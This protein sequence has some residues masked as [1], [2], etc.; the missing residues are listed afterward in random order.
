M[1]N[2]T[3]L[4]SV[5][6]EEKN[7]HRC[8]DC[9]S[10]FSEIIVID[11]NS[12][13]KTPEIV[14]E[15]GYEL[16]NFEWNGKFPK[17]RNWALRNLKIKNDWVLFLDA[18]E[19]VNHKFC[20]EL[21]AKIEE[22]NCN[23]FW[24]SYDNYFLGKKLS[25]GDT[26]RK[27]PLIRLGTGEFEKIDEDLWSHLDMEVHEHLIVAGQVGEMKSR[28]DHQDYKGIEAYIK[29]HNAYS[30]SEAHRFLKVYENWDKDWRFLLVENWF[31]CLN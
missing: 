6:N 7:L 30:S 27:L 25:Y 23:G 19:F 9:L 29:R 3:V 21:K 31:S 11:S 12:S 4:I 13:D 26:M 24:V 28:I 14:K 5:K 22:T 17:K 18:D 15:F 1:I 16:V 2:V 20:Y 8:L 10:D